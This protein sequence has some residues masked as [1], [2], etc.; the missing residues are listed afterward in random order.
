M[1]AF[2]FYYHFWEVIAEGG[3]NKVLAENKKIYRKD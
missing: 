3:K 2:G 1:Q